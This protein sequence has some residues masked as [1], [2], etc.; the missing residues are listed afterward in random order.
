MEEV[1]I[2]TGRAQRTFENARAKFLANDTISQRN[3]DLVGRYL[4][5][6]ALGKTILGRAKKK[7][8]P[9]RLS[10]YVYHLTHVINVVGKDIDQLSQE[11]MER[12][13]EA[14]ETNKIENRWVSPPRCLTILPPRPLSLHYSVDLKVSVKKFYKW[15]LGNN[16]T[17]PPLVDWIDTYARHK[18]ISSLTPGEVQ[19]MLDCSTS[20]R[21]KAIIQVLFDGGFRRDEFLNVRLRHLRKMTFVASGEQHAC[22]A[23]R[24]VFSKTLART[25]VLPM[26]ATTRLLGLW[27]Q[28][29]PGKPTVLTDGTIA[30]QDT[31]L[32]LFPVSSEGLAVMV[33]RLGRKA[34]QKRVYPHLLRH[35]SATYWANKLPYFK[36]CKRFG[37]TMTSKM[38]QRYIDREGVDELEVAKIYQDSVQQ[39]RNQETALL[40]RV[41]EV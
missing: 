7:V 16:R 38:P 22:F 9:A 39:E 14:L 2:D 21:Q 10:T 20:I 41:D 12:F 18:E 8:G 13:I 19:A 36:F 24:V 17:Y 37:W 1:H 29:H 30:A 31:S 35:T 23:A 28:K 40:A 27:L 11:D 6:A 4:R 33:R 5:E 15:L 32:P 3:R 34:V 25:V 26:D